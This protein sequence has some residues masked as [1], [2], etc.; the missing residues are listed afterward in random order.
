MQPFFSLLLHISKDQIIKSFPSSAEQCCSCRPC[1]ESIF[2][3]PASWFSNSWASSF[4]KRVT[5][6]FSWSKWYALHKVFPFHLSGWSLP[7]PLL[8]VPGHP[9][10]GADSQ[11]HSV[12][13]RRS[14]GSCPA[15][16]FFSFSLF[17]PLLFTTGNTDRI[18][19]ESVV[20]MDKLAWIIYKLK[21]NGRWLEN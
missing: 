13:S 15:F 11:A 1:T 7:L 14:M 19:G 10:Q 3:L 5:W 16:C 20:T 8:Y 12:S 4:L 2:L 9:R 21:T 18:R 17:F 6:I